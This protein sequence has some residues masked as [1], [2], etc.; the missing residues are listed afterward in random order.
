[1][2]EW[3]NTVLFYVVSGCRSI[4]HC[5]ALLSPHQ[6]LCPHDGSQNLMVAAEDGEVASRQKGR[7]LPFLTICGFGH[8]IQTTWGPFD[9][10]NLNWNS[11]RDIS[12]KPFD[13]NLV[14]L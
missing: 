1:M 12:S 4:A 9:L 10:M 6:L 7:R 11:H 8:F 14:Y 13:P 2:G 5:T 3:S